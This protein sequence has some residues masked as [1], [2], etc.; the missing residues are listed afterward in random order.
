MFAS[1]LIFACLILTHC[2]TG[3]ASR[4]AHLPESDCLL[5]LDVMRKMAAD[6]VDAVKLQKE[7]VPVLVVGGG[8][9]LY[10]ATGDS[11]PGASSVN[12]PEGYSVANAVGA[13]IAQV[14]CLLSSTTCPSRIYRINTS[15]VFYRTHIF[16]FL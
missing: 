6:V 4:V 3:D 11:I 13:A 1:I 10:S 8:A 14:R 5:A 15:L 2:S 12:R 9:V 7:Q 16:V